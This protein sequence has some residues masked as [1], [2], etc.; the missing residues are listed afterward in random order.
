V[1]VNKSLKLVI[2]TLFIIVLIVFTG[3][4][5]IV[6]SINY[7]PEISNLTANSDTI[8]AG[9]NTIITCYATDPDGDQL[10]YTW[11]KTEGIISGNG[12][13]IAW[14]APATTG[15][16]TIT[17]SVSDGKGGEDNKL[18]SIQVFV[19]NQTPKPMVSGVE[20]HAATYPLS[21]SKVLNR[22]IQKLK[23]EN[24]KGLLQDI[25][26]TNTE[27]QRRGEIGYGIEL[28][29]DIYEGAS[30][31]KIY[32]SVNGANYVV[33]FEGTDCCCYGSRRC[34]FFDDNTEESNVYFYYITAYG[35]NWETI[36]SEVVFI[37]TWLP[38]CYLISPL[39]NEVIDNPNPTFTWSPVGLSDF[40]YGPI[41]GGYSDF[42]VYDLTD[43]KV[44][45]NIL[46]IDDMTT[47]NATYNQDGQASPLIPG[48]SYL[49]NSWGR[50]LN[51]NY[52]EIAISVSE[53]W[54]FT[55]SGE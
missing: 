26:F 52:N 16:Y 29:W 35:V 50:G 19:L 38:S 25:N 30:G 23:G 13:I 21:K 1:F 39:N 36:P 12:S 40:P 48:H 9:H 2:F 11:T 41:C 54:V 49:W 33:V 24:S 27:E 8:E 46:F 37:D 20:A 42:F 18:V 32:K 15:T 5:G 43:K 31:Y 44:V 53:D 47:S 17:C 22:I 34:Y 45:Q 6:S 3:C 51:E 4:G 10:T 7:P 14:T 55:Y 28:F